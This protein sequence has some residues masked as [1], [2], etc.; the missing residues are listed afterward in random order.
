MG[1]YWVSKIGRGPKKK[2]QKK[3]TKPKAYLGSL[4]VGW[5]GLGFGGSAEADLGRY[6]GINAPT[7][8]N[9]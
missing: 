9:D 6:L 7:T 8:L 5:A 1:P 3:K 4:F 2:K